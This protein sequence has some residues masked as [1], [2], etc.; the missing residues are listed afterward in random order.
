MLEQ[1]QQR[2]SDLQDSYIKIWEA[3]QELRDEYDKLFAEGDDVAKK[4]M[5]INNSYLEIKKVFLIVS[6]SL[7]YSALYVK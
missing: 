2:F 3:A 6:R 4:I 5:N 1:I 7:G